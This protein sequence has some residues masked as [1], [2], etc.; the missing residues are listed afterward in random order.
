[1]SSKDDFRNRRAR[2]TSCDYLDPRWRSFRLQKFASVRWRCEYTGCPENAE[3]CHH[4]I[5]LPDR[6]IWEYHL[7]EVQAICAF[8][9]RRAHMQRNQNPAQL[10]LFG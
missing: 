6:H 10:E 5:Y 7:D 9:H 8:H 2:S 3:I 1:M 4:K